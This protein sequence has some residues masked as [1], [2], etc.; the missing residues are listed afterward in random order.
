M[1]AEIYRAFGGRRGQWVVLVE[2]LDPNAA[3]A[4]ADRIAEKLGALSTHVE[5]VDALTALVPAPQTQLARFDERDA[6]DLGA[7]SVELRTAL[8]EV[9]F[10]A[11][12]FDALLERMKQPPRTL[13]RLDDIEQSDAAILVSRYL[14][15]DEGRTLSKNVKDAPARSGG[16]LQR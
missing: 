14:G 16:Q 6:L 8:T 1:Q 11:E 12:R 10:A 15:S 2:D 4:R 9:G 3:Q 7:K 13:V 5:S